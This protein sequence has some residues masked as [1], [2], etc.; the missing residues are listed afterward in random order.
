MW[1]NDS[2][3]QSACF[4]IC[5]GLHWGVAIGKVELTN[6]LKPKEESICSLSKTKQKMD[7]VLSD[8][9]TVLKCNA[10]HQEIDTLNDLCESQTEVL[11]LIESHRDQIHGKIH[12][13]NC[14]RH[15]YE[16]HYFIDS[17]VSLDPIS[18]H[19]GNYAGHLAH[20]CWYVKTMKPGSPLNH[21]EETLKLHIQQ[22]KDLKVKL[23]SNEGLANTN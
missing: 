23:E 7:Q 6:Q 13:Q 9:K 10:S 16:L 19:L 5:L 18:E 3:N 2:N 22:L 20:R 17:I 12:S 15:I 21:E 8:I 11:R 14:I 4:E 1:I